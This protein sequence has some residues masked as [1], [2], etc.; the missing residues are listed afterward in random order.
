MTGTIKP[1]LEQREFDSF[2]MDISFFAG[3]PILGHDIR[4]GGVSISWN[5]AGVGVIEGVHSWIKGVF[6]R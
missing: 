6:R 1:I 3:H 2:A 5:F 4:I